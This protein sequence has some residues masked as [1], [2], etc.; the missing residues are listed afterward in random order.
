MYNSVKD[1]V[2]LIYKSYNKVSGMLD[3]RKSDQHNRMPQL[4]R[5]LLD[6]QQAPDAG[7]K[8]VLVTGSKGKGSTSRLLAKILEQFGLKVGLFTS[9]HLINFT[10][11]IRVNGKAI[12]DEDFLQTA[13][14]I[15]PDVKRI[16][17]TLQGEEYIGPVGVAL[18]IAMVYFRKCN[19]DID[20]LECGRGG[21]FD[22]VNVV[23][24]QWS[25][26]TPILGE[27]VLQLGPLTTDIA[28][29]KAG[30]IKSTCK[31]TFVAKQTTD[32]MEEILKKKHSKFYIIGQDALLNRAEL[33]R[34]GLLL[35]VKTDKTY[36]DMILPTFAEYQG[37]NAALAIM[38]AEQISSD[39]WQGGHNNLQ[40]NMERV[41]R[42]ALESFKWPGRCQLI[43]YKP[44]VLV[45]GAITG[46]SA[47]HLTKALG[48]IGHE[49]IISIIG[50]PLDKEYE[51]VI[52]KLASTSQQVI[53]TRSIGAQF[54]FPKDALKVALK[55]QKNSIETADFTAAINV[56]LEK[57]DKNRGIICVAGTQSLVGDAVNYFK[58]N[59]ED[60][61]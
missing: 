43:N 25:V 29:N 27:H 40:L 4:T 56:A 20:I 18:T 44:M 58:V 47:E 35:S 14:Q 3:S 8:I 6:L 45:D 5:K 48:A 46:I 41:V 19:T 59:L 49:P 28:R 39:M 15:A 50:V 21:L 30:I 31:K 37:E 23:E 10:E 51:S 42:T 38:A 36:E 7:K 32:V 33:T 12:S 1:A 34:D 54:P 17:T 60:L 26:I 16:Q 52:A 24:N 55:Y 9:P 22:D 2:D 11:R 61:S 53:I 13:N 57:V